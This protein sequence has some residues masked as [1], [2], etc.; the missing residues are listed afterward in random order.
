[1]NNNIL[2]L[3]IPG[4]LEHDDLTETENNEQKSGKFYL[5]IGIGMRVF[6]FDIE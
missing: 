2:F 1:M 3:F 4:C 5:L 6:V